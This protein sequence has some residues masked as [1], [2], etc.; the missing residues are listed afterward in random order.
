ML[1]I[2]KLKQINISTNMKKLCCTCRKD[3]LLE[4]FYKDRNKKDGRNSRCK[5]IKHIDF[6][7][8]EHK[9]IIGRI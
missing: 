1:Q 6:R 2:A 8:E 9:K 4:E 7:N 3:K 5:N